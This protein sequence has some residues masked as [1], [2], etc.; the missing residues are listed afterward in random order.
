MVVVVEF[1]LLVEVDKLVIALLISLRMCPD[2]ERIVQSIRADLV[3]LAADDRLA[4][5]RVD[6]V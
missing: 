1:H 5:L 3:E 4:H 2:V 6:I